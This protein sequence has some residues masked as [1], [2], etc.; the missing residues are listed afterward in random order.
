VPFSYGV[1]MTSK[2]LHW[3]SMV[4]YCLAVVRYC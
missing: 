2:A 1:V 3:Y 4:E